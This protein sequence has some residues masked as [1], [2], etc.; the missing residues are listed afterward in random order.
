LEF[1][2]DTALM[3]EPFS[4]ISAEQMELSSVAVL[5]ARDGTGELAGEGE[6]HPESYEFKTRNRLPGQRP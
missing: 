2:D 4:Y 6:K 3:T 1:E 5:A